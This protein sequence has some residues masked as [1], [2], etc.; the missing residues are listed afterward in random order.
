LLQLEKKLDLLIASKDTDCSV[1][2]PRRSVPK[3]NCAVGGPRWKITY[4]Q[5]LVWS[6][7]KC[8]GALGRAKM[9]LWS[10]MSFPF[11]GC[12]WWFLSQLQKF[13]FSL[14]GT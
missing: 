4:E 8:V 12:C 11:F 5:C 14:A 2:R 3:E 13:C 10:C 7:Q 1:E 6:S 9:L